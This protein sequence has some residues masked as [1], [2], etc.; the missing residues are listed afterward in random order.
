MVTYY[1]YNT[2]QVHILKNDNNPYKDAIELRRIAEERLAAMEVATNASTSA[3]DVIRLVHE[4]QV[5]QIEL[6]LQNEE[7]QQSRAEVEAVLEKYTELYDFA[8]VGYFSLDRLGNI[9]Q[10][11]LA[12]ANLLGLP[13]PRL[14]NGRLGFFVSPECRTVYNAF[15][16]R[17]FASQTK[18][19]CEILLIT[20]AGAPIHVQ[21]E[22]IVIGNGEEC[23]VAVLDITERKM[24][25]KALAQVS[26]RDHYI[27]EMLQQLILPPKI[28]M[29]TKGYEI[30]TR[31]IPALQEAE[32]CGDFYDVFDMG[33]GKIGILIGDIVGKGLL[34]ASRVAA[35]RHTIRSYALLDDRPSTIMS[36][37]N[38]ALCRDITTENDMF[39]AFLAVLDVGTGNLTYSN[40]GHVSPVVRHSDGR[41][42]SLIEGGAMFHGLGRQ[43]YSE[44][45]LN[46]C[47]G[48]M[49]VM[50]TDGIT[51]ARNESSP[52]QFELPGIV[53][54][55]SANAN[56]SAELIASRL[57]ETAT[58]YVD[59]KFRDDVAVVVVKRV[60]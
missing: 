15:L 37:V 42:E 20:D 51:E 34:A 48:D 41:V 52:E 27:A 32:V 45:A 40:A 54:C 3:P 18:Q 6:E 13:R 14:K 7:L 31:Y 9:L 23:H 19:K 12:G 21:T 11:N 49:L 59:G 53:S 50:V 36:L 4:L 44:G 30:A 56:N 8:P 46:I 28:S 55:L 26:E 58:L 16:E 25:E 38:D 35:I 5:H 17:V 2:L 47:V 33:K 1:P 22:A 10:L 60:E 39:T 24:A 29:Q 43:L 57:V